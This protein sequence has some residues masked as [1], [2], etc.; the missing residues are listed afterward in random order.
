MWISTD[1][2][3]GTQMQSFQSFVITE[4]FQSSKLY[5]NNALQPH[6]CQYFIWSVGLYPV[7]HYYSHLPYRHFYQIF[8][9]TVI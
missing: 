1:H 9:L 3:P 5:S 2:F 4:A 6:R 8:P 7:Y